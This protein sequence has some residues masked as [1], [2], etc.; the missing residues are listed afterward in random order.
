[1]DGTL[2]LDTAR[3]GRMRLRA[4]DAATDFAR[5]CTDEGGSRRVEELLGGGYRAW[6]DPLC[7]RYPGLSDWGG[8]AS[9][10]RD[11]RSL[12][13]AP[14]ESE[15]L[16]AA[17]SATLMRIAARTLARRCRR[18]LH[19]D[20]EWGSYVGLL[21]G[22]ARRNV[23][24]I[25][26]LPV[27]RLIVERMI[28]PEEVT[29]FV[30]DAC[31]RQSALGLF[32]TDISHDGIR[33][34]VAA[35]VRELERRGERPLVIVDGS[36]AIGQAPAAI[37]GCDLYLGGA[38][39]WLRAGHP[40]GIAVAPRLATRECF[41]RVADEL[42]GSG[43]AGDPLLDFVHQ[44]G[45]EGSHPYGETA[46][47]GAVFCLAA[48]VRAQIAERSG[49]EGHFRFRL[50]NAARVRELAREV[51]W[52]PLEMSRAFRSGIQLLIA[53]ATELQSLPAER[54]RSELHRRGVA[55]TAYAGGLVRLSMIGELWEGEDL[56]VIRSALTGATRRQGPFALGGSDSAS[57]PAPERTAIMALP[58]MLS[59]CSYQ[60]S[61]EHPC[62]E[63]EVQPHEEPE[64]A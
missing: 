43:E 64:I 16:L 36:Q 19:T 17:R 55:G 27:R 42:V 60:V 34:P 59:N 25:V 15:I 47:L 10:R 45:R 40:I 52:E 8:L 12:L 11:L 23:G 26:S 61:G 63:H 7:R 1:V 6:P 2:Y 41:A 4:R 57:R 3:F 13:G 56:H 24:E 21:R 54:L 58:T 39:K 30:A 38:Q 32:L 20:L 5:L 62:A 31:R 35:V 22:E 33:F 29:Q 18:I 37:E 44:V 14:P 53:T 28:D 9:L 50:A 51:G 48:A 49:V 46:D